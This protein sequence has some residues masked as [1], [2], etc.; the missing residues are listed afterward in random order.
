MPQLSRLTAG[1]YYTVINGAHAG[2]TGIAV[3]SDFDA[4]AQWLTSP[5]LPRIPT[6][7][8]L[9][10]LR[11]ATPQEIETFRARFGAGGKTE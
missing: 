9:G 8:R 4:D 1:K 2:V 6:S 10:D 7:G 11:E 3:T 5:D